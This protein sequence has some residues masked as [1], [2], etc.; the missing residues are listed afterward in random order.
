MKE[1]LVLISIDKDLDMTTCDCWDML[2]PAIVSSYNMTPNRMTKYSPYSL[3]FG[4]HFR[5]P[6]DISLRECQVGKKVVAYDEAVVQLREALRVMRAAVH[7]NQ[8]TYDNGR[9][10][11][12]NKGRVAHSFK[13]G[14][15][16][17]WFVGDR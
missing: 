6:T 2:I 17:M 13:I 1:R 7:A 9:A 15:L 4:R 16:V 10:T 12:E 14:D 11:Y 5:L 3:I 8:T